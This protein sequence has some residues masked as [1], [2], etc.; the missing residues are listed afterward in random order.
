MSGQL[1]PTTLPCRGCSQNTESKVVDSRPAGIGDSVRR[2]RECLECGYRFTTRELYI[3][4]GEFYKFLDK[5]GAPLKQWRP[6][7]RDRLLAMKNTIEK[8]LAAMGDS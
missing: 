8:E 2:R 7:H 6:T 5:I 1:G 4:D 3:T